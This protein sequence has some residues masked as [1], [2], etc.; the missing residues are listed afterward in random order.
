MYH[1][2]GSGFNDQALA[3]VVALSALVD[4][5]HFSVPDSVAV[6]LGRLSAFAIDLLFHTL[7]SFSRLVPKI[8]LFL[9]P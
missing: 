9:G 1:F 4:G 7:F 3:H 5:V 2:L 8:V 6:D